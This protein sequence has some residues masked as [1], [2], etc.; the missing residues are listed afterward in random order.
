VCGNVFDVPAATAGGSTGGGGDWV[1]ERGR[2]LGDTQGIK[3]F[4]GVFAALR[5]TGWAY[6]IDSWVEG[7]GIFGFDRR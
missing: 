1:D 5:M 4:A 3:P 6:E 2:G 7:F